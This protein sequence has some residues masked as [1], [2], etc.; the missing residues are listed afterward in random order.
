[1]PEH[2]KAHLQ[3]SRISKFFSEGPPLS[4]EWEHNLH[5]RT[6]ITGGELRRLGEQRGWKEGA[7][8]ELEGWGGKHFPNKNLRLRQWQ[9]RPL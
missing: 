5:R 7:R 1:M 3:Q 2:A 6:I 8:R 4:G 9:N